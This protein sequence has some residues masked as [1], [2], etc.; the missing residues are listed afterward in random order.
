MLNKDVI[1]AQLLQQN[2]Q[3]NQQVQLLTDEKQ[4]LREY[5]K[6]L[7][8]KI[9]RLKK[10]SSNSP[11]PPSSDIT[12]PQP[13]N[14]KKKKRKIGSQKGHPKHSRPLFKASEIDKTIVHWAYHRKATPACYIFSI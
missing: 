9:A 10:N 1:I 3:L 7:E 4:Q 6:F 14:K 5:I 8:E 2:E 11:K 13:T 12:N